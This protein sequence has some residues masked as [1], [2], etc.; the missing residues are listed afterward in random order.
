M[1]TRKSATARLAVI[2][3]GERA[4]ELFGDAPR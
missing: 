4:H 3:A 2:G 1:P